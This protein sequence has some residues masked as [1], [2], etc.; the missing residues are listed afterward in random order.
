MN[1]LKSK[2]VFMQ[3]TFTMKYAAET[4]FLLY[5][6]FMF[7]TYSERELSVSASSLVLMCTAIKCGRVYNS[8]R[9]AFRQR[10]TLIVS[11][12]GISMKYLA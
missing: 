4:V 11:S 6:D 10:C 2:T 1:F 12:G 3:R 5:C 9:F 7:L 8:D